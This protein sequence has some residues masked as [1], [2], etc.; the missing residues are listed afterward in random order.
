M[1]INDFNR[2]CEDQKMQWTRGS[3]G[4]EWIPKFFQLG[5]YSQ[6]F[7]IFW[8]TIYIF[9]WLIVWHQFKMLTFGS[10][11]FSLSVQRIIRQ[12][13]FILGNLIH[14][15]SFPPEISEFFC[16]KECAHDSQSRLIVKIP[17]ST[18][19]INNQLIFEPQDTNFWIVCFPWFN[20]CK[21]IL[22]KFNVWS[23]RSNSSHSV[24]FRTHRFVPWRG[25]GPTVPP[26]RGR[27]HARHVGSDERTV[28]GDPP[29]QIFFKY[30]KTSLV[31]C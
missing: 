19:K 17:I 18:E 2:I 21:S 10:G 6:R 24:W 3:C 1:Q 28:K 29:H 9:F 15:L 7:Y 23:D 8:N 11:Q 20:L 31:G 12:L 27:E 14:H 5:D 13:S 4:S 30:L 16:L 25:S 26:R 22:A